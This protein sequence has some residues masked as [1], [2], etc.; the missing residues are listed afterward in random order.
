MLDLPMREADVAIRM[1]EPSQADLIRK[2]LM[3]GQ[4]AA[5]RLAATILTATR[6][7]RSGWRSC[8]SHRLIC[9]NTGL[10]PGRR[11][12]RAGAAAAGLRHAVDPDGQQLLRR[13]AGG[14]QQSR[15]RRAAR[16]PDRGLPEPR[17]GS[18]RMSN[19]TR[20]RSSSPIPRNCAIPSGSRRSA[21]SS[22]RK[23]SPIARDAEQDERAA[24]L[25]HARNAWPPCCT[26]SMFFL[27]P[28][29]GIA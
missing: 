27:D 26:R 5:L 19:A 13:A 28:Q 23:S 25:R 6:H 21:I 20:C 4:H 24:C 1:K 2:R 11:R 14:A 16:L 12:R 3:G 9:Q 10:R 15:H 17:R 18:C 22:P 8:R 29:D 7:A